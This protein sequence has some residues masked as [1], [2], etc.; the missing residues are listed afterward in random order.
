M[1][2]D[3]RLNACV[4]YI[5][6]VLVDTSSSEKKTVSFMFSFKAISLLSYPLNIYE[7]VV[8]LHVTLLWRPFDAFL[9]HMFHTFQR[10]IIFFY[11]RM[12]TTHQYKCT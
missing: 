12:I 4:V 8:F 11:L 9:L 10:I 7:Y 6:F 2:S 5:V 3:S 1:H